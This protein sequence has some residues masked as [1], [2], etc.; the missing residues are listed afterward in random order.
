MT[1]ARQQILIGGT[2]HTKTEAT[3]HF[4]AML[5][6]YLINQ[7]VNAADQAALADIIKRHPKRAEKLGTG[8]AEFRVVGGGRFGTRCFEILRTDRTA[9]TFSYLACISPE[10]PGHAPEVFW[11]MRCEI[12][13]QTRAF[14]DVSFKRSVVFCEITGKPIVRSDAHV[15]HIKPLTFQRLVRD[16]LA[17]RGTR[18]DDVRVER[19]EGTTSV[20]ADRDLATA[21]QE[22]HRT[23]AKLRIASKRANLKERK[24]VVDFRPTPTLF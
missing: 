8:I 7:P 23:H 22:Y 13:V 10:A 3:R 20:L 19:G 12:M 11:A 17:Q 2:P 1:R 18:L 21:W 5:K 16:F 9:V 24:P 4:R 15:D 6:R 14:F